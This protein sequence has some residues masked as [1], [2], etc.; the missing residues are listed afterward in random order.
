MK[1]WK[2]AL[3]AI[4]VFVAVYLAFPPKAFAESIA[5]M[6]NKG[7]GKIVLT[8]DTCNMEGKSYPNLN[9]AYNYTSEG[10]SSEGCYTLE[11]ETVIIVWNLN[12]KAQKMRYAVDDF[13][14]VKRKQR[15]GTQI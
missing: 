4:V 1:S 10:Y 12:G 13:T 8:N 2:V 6:P 5:T 7:G 15:G 14:L 3:G 9:R 11:D